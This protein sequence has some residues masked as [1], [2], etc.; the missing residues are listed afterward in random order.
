[1]SSRGKPKSDEEF[2]ALMNQVAY[3]LF[4]RLGIRQGLLPRVSFLGTTSVVLCSWPRR[5]SEL[6]PSFPPAHCCLTDSRDWLIE[7]AQ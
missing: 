7:T 2:A 6:A 1:V 4:N 5:A 3:P